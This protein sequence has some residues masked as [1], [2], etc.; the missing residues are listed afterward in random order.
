MYSSWTF[1]VRTH[2][3]LVLVSAINLKVPTDNTNINFPSYCVSWKNGNLKK[4]RDRE[5]FSWNVYN[6]P[7][8]ANQGSSWSPSKQQYKWKS[9]LASVFVYDYCVYRSFWRWWHRFMAPCTHD[10]F[11]CI[12]KRWHKASFYSYYRS[13]KKRKDEK[14][15]RLTTTSKKSIIKLRY[16][17]EPLKKITLMKLCY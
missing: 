3:S 2:E 14:C 17:L 8:F 13:S 1:I 11:V 9:R 4:K 10:L 16:L 12:Y 6:F 7:N 5:E 15:F